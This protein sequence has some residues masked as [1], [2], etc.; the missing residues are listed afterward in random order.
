MEEFFKVNLHVTRNDGKRARKTSPET[1]ESVAKRKTSP[2]KT[3]SVA[4]RKNTEWKTRCLRKQ[5]Q[6]QHQSVLLVLVLW[7]VLIESKS[8]SK[9]RWT[10][11]CSET[12]GISVPMCCWD[13]MERHRSRRHSHLYWFQEISGSSRLK[14][15]LWLGVCMRVSRYQCYS[16]LV[17]ELY[18]LNVV[19]RTRRSVI[20]FLVGTLVFGVR[21]VAD[22]MIGY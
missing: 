12:K 15:F 7:P 4:R 9:N 21:T 11:S 16:F 3:K 19:C 8:G 13:R 2:E 17:F 18:V 22:R 6:Q 5:Q 10:I 14:M 1:T 20:D